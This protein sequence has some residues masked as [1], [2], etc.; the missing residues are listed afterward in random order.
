MVRIIS[1][2]TYNMGKS[3]SIKEVNPATAFYEDY[4][5]K[6]ALLKNWRDH[7]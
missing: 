7:M 5:A 4:K 1:N 3:M 2:E 6:T